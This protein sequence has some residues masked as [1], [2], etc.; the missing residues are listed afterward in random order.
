MAQE[1]NPNDHQMVDNMTNECMQYMNISLS[2]DSNSAIDSQVMSSLSAMMSS[3]KEETPDFAVVKDTLDGHNNDT[4]TDNIAMNKDSEDNTHINGNYEE[5]KE[6]A[7]DNCNNDNSNVININEMVENTNEVVSIQTDIK[8]T[9]EATVEAISLQND[10]LLNEIKIVKSLVNL[11]ENYR[12]LLNCCLNSCD[13]CSQNQ[14]I[15]VK[16]TNLETNYSKDLIFAKELIIN[17]SFHE[18]TKR[19][20][21]NRRRNKKYKKTTETKLIDEYIS[22]DD[23]NDVVIETLDSDCDPISDVVDGDNG[24]LRRNRKVV[25]KVT[26]RGPKKKKRGRGR[27]PKSSYTQQQS[28]NSFSGNLIE[29]IDEIIDNFDEIDEVV[30]ETN[31][32]TYNPKKTNTKPTKTPQKRGPKKGFKRGV[33]KAIKPKRNKYEKLYKCDVCDYTHRKLPNLES[34][35]NKVHLNIRPFK[36][37]KCDKSFTGKPFLDKHRR[38]HQEN[39]HYCD[40]TDC[41]FKTKYMNNLKE[42]RMRHEKD[43][44]F[45][46]AWPGCGALFYNNRDLTQHMK[47]HEEQRDY[48]CDWPGCEAT[49]KRHTYLSRHKQLHIN[50]DT[51]FPCNW[52]GCEKS[53]NTRKKLENHSATHT[54]QLQANTQ[55]FPEGAPS[56]TQCVLPIATPTTSS[57]MLSPRKPQIN[58]TSVQLLA[59]RSIAQ[60][61]VMNVNNGLQSNQSHESMVPTTA[62]SNILHQHHHNHHQSH[63]SHHNQMSPQQQQHQQHHQQQ[64]QQHHQQQQQ[65]H[66]HQMHH[67]QHHHQLQQQHIL[68][69]GPPTPSISPLTQYPTDLSQQR[70]LPHSATTAQLSSNPWLLNSFINR[71]NI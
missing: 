48:R 23:N 11:L 18:K 15:S 8:D 39:Y 45:R 54:K 42:H 7:I 58:A 59:A 10:E 70:P 71:Q 3:I 9:T 30:E 6:D 66:H 43:R 64:Q 65:Q 67:Q 36:C 34:H 52:P 51:A 2:T 38:F 60:A 14:E 68:R 32:N 21:A 26:K 25:K 56:V 46:C 20:F 22:N 63:Q 12:N 19:L 31:D 33:T 50:P 16:F 55:T 27:P 40:W 69:A 41:T 35:K 13:N 4:N 28:F 24:V 44:Q 17:S 49:F 1:V 61:A 62:N 5:E 47:S 29:E 37:D 57:Q 53:F